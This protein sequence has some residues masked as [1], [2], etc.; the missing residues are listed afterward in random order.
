M[1]PHQYGKTLS[2][3]HFDSSTVE[4]VWQKAHTILGVHPSVIRKDTCGAPIARNQYGV[5][6]PGGMGWEIDHILPVSLGGSD[7]LANL[8]P[9]QWQNNRS[10]SDFSLGQ[11][12]CHIA[13][14]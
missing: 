4:L 14:N 8:Q 2:N 7:T 13:S 11:W 5:M 10:K 3:S 6:V 1:I 9:L 12:A